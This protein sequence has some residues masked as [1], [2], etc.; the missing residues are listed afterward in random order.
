VLAR[1]NSTVLSL[2]DRLHVRNVAK[3]LRAFDAHPEQ[4]LQLL[5]TGFCSSS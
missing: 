5:L 2:M 4:A 1:L 3:Q